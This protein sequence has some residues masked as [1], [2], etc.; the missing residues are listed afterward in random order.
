MTDGI[1][2]DADVDDGVDTVDNDG[3][4]VIIPPVFEEVV[5]EPKTEGDVLISVIG[6]AEPDVTA[7]DGPVVLATNEPGVPFG[8]DNTT[9]LDDTTGGKT[10]P[11]GVGTVFDGFT[12][13]TGGTEVT[14]GTV[15]TVD[16]IL[17]TDVVT[18]TGF[19]VTD[20]TDDTIG[21]ITFVGHSDSRSGE[22]HGLVDG[23][24]Y[25]WLPHD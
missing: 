7:S 18:A 15:V 9:A 19:C 13:V 14:D 12:E 20:V 8:W 10:G 16:G 1:V 2:V 11:V 22:P 4:G 24:G 17:C 5:I 21:N 23:H 25:G 3:T 6:T